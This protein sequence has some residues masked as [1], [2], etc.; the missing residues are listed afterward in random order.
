[1]LVSD[2]VDAGLLTAGTQ[3][4]FRRKQSGEAHLAKV[5]GDGRIELSDGQQFKSPSSTTSVSA[6]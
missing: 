4:T 1:V 2:L 6:R 5:T 3:L